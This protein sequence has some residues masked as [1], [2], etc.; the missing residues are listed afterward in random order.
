LRGQALDVSLVS[1]GSVPADL[2]ALVADYE[3]QEH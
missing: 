1:Y 3:Q 2:Q